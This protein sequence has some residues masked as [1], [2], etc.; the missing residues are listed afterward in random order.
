MKSLNIDALTKIA[1]KHIFDYRTQE[2]IG[3]YRD[4]GHWWEVIES[5]TNKIVGERFV[6][7]YQAEIE[8]DR[9]NM[10]AGVAEIVG[11]IQR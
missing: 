11:M 6:H 10:R 8:R 2:V 3:G 5:K 4:P 1:L 7:G 9:L